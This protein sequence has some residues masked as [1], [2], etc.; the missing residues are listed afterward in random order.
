MAFE[1]VRAYQYIADTVEDLK[2]IK[3]NKIGLECYVIQEAC[4]YKRMST[5]EW[6][7]Q[8]PNTTSGGGGGNGANIDLSKYATKDYV[9]ESINNLEIPSIEGLATIDYVNQ[10]IESIPTLDDEGNIFE[11]G[12]I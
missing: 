9:N 1:K 10:K 2:L 5:G 6:V 3:E 7:R 4:E 11:G 8:I 12:E